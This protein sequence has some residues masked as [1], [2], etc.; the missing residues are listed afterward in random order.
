MNVKKKVIIV[1]QMQ[2]VSTLMDLSPASVREVMRV[3]GSF[4]TRSIPPELVQVSTL[5][6]IAERQ[7]RIRLQSD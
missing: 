2:N 5:L 1:I 4:V 7:Y 3:M 6:F